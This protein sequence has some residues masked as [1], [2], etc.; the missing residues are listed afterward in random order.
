[1]PARDGT[2]PRGE[3]TRTGRGLG[4]CTLSLSQQIWRGLGLG[5]CGRG[6]AWGRRHG[7]GRG[8]IRPEENP[9]T[10]KEEN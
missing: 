8:R 1:M 7:G 6:Q 2:G 4:K 9:A 10:K 5:P 3:G